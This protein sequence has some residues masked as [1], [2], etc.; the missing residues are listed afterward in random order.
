ME[1][2]TDKGGSCLRSSTYKVEPGFILGLP[3]ST[4]C[5]TF[6]AKP[7]V[8]TQGS[9]TREVDAVAAA[10]CCSLEGCLRDLSSGEVRILDSG[11]GRDFR[12]N[13][14]EARLVLAEIF[15]WI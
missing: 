5:F 1:R 14:C 15:T 12:M 9:G 2:P 7:T 4:A 8:G 10:T 13:Q 11:A 6:N 3:G